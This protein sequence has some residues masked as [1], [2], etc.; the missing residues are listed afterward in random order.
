M[1]DERIPEAQAASEEPAAIRAPA[2]QSGPRP[3]ESAGGEAPRK[4]RRRGSRGGRNRRRPGANGG[5]AAG[6]AEGGTEVD[7]GAADRPLTADDVAVE[8][9]DDAGL[10]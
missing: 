5:A 6:G 4:R 8:A 2:E 10:D 9:R 3:A 7:L 1:S